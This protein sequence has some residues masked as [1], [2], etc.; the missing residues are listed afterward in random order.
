MTWEKLS[1]FSKLASCMYPD[2]VDPTI[3]AQ[4]EKLAKGEGKSLR[5]ANTLSDEAR[6][7]V[8]PLGNV[9]SGWDKL[10]SK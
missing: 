7:H 3:R 1:R 9:A 5:G 8:S 6:K 10:R 4:M 2:L